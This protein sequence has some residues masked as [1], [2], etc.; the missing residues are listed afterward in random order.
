MSTRRDFLKTAGC[1]TAAML[2]AEGALASRREIHVDGKRVKV[3]DLHAHC[4]IPEAA[5]MTAQGAALM[6]SAPRSLIRSLT[7]GPQRLESMDARGIDIQVLSV[8]QYWWYAADRDL[9]ARTVQAQDEGLAAWC[10]SHP[11]RF[12]GLTSVALQYPD[13]AAQQL[14]YAVEEL[15]LRG[16]SIG[17]HVNGEAPTSAKYD[18]FWRRAEEL[19]VTVFMHPGGA[20]NV[21]RDHAL[22]GRG[23][24]DN[25][26]GNPLETTVFLS[27]MIFDGVLDRFP[28]LN[29]SAA[30][31]GG[32][33]PSY[34]G[35][36]EVACKY[37]DDAN[38]ANRKSPSEYLRT[39]IL[40]D[41]MIFSAEG[42][43]HLVAEVGASQIAYGSDI[44]FDWPD[45]IDL[46]VE[47][48]TLSAAQKTAILGGN[49]LK[50]LRIGPQ[51]RA[52]AR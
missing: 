2:M 31:A 13:L 8:N 20:E 52:G 45:T 48:P 49:L 26:I 42:L 24:L 17:G 3:V 21:I 51:E 32:Y 14:Q 5:K 6:R 34:L 25:V 47:A 36:S 41:S 37:R 12:V 40:V 23:D 39:Q 38:C 18:P 7:L 1:A 35:R 19:G 28:R 9:A 29:I 4:F 44:P 16:A 27:R 10:N 46:I 43:R 11:D 22:E 33:L 30:H 50:L 15:G